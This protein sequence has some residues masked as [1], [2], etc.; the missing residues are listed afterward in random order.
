[1]FGFIGLVVV[2]VFIMWL[3]SSSSGCSG[4]VFTSSGDLSGDVGSLSGKSSG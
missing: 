2:I 3:A 1:V 4:D